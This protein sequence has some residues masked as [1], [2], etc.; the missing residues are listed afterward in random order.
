MASSQHY[1]KI[2]EL[3]VDQRRKRRYQ[4]GRFMGR[5]GFARCYEVTDV[6]SGEVFACKLV[7][8]S[9]LVKA[10]HKEKMSQEITI[11]KTLQHPHVVQFFNYLEDEQYIYIILEICSNRSLMEMHKRRKTLSEPETRYFVR[12]IVESCVYLHENRIVHRDLKLGNLFLSDAMEIKLGDFG[13]AAQIDRDN[14]KRRT[15]CGTP[16]YIAPEV[17]QR[18]GHGFTAD[19]WSLGCILYTLLV[20]RPPFE[21][22]TLKATYDRIKKAEFIMPSRVSASARRLINQ[23]LQSTPDQRPSMQ[24]IL[25]DPFFSA[26][27]MPLALPTSCL[28]MAPRFMDRE[29]R[30]P[31]PID[32][33]QE[34]AAGSVATRGG[35]RG[36]TV[37]TVSGATSATNENANAKPLAE[38]PIDGYLG[39]LK[40]ILTK[41]IAD[42]KQKDARA[43]TAANDEAIM[44]DAEDPS[45]A[46]MIWLSKWLDYSDRYGLGYQLSDKSVGV[47]F[48]DSTKLLLFEESDQLQ[49]V[50]AKGKEAY[51]NQSKFPPD[52]RKKVVLLNY[53][54]NYMRENLLTA[55]SVVKRPDAARIARLPWLGTWFRTKSAINLHLTNGSLQ[56]NFFTDHVKIIFCPL[57]GAVSVIQPGED[58]R[59]Y[60]L[61]SLRK[62]GCSALLARRLRYARDICD[63]LEK[64]RINGSCKLMVPRDAATTAHGEQSSFVDEAHTKPAVPV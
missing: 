63:K 34:T 28:T 35:G 27:F 30:R 42:V 45:L 5:G 39:A 32:A 48:N 52:L 44:D 51:Y 12:Q 17:L 50:D 54:N 60:S 47:L 26:G 3:I 43:E 57:M 40:D 8:K 37:G 38:P 58:M 11:H 15:L 21:S 25:K 33:V 55:G 16:N 29:T 20:G 9:L 1:P 62:T 2:P 19:V 22:S 46:P 14:E 53:F 10:H 41:V 24:E 64:H 59:T 6:D 13:L 36:A 23:M 61:A 31:I 4:R 56:I 49:F 18:L 7:A